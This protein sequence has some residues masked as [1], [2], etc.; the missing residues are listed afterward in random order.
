MAAPP[1]RFG[2]TLSDERIRG[3]AFIG[4]DGRTLTP[5]Y[6]VENADMRLFGGAQVRLRGCP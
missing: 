5:G 1:N 4:P 3:G 2:E 6:A